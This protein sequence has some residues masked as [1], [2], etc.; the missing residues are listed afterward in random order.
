[1]SDQRLRELERQAQAGGSDERLRRERCRQGE[2]CAGH[3]PNPWPDRA[4]KQF[5]VLGPNWWPVWST[6]RSTENLAQAVLVRDDGS[7]PHGSIAAAGW[8]RLRAQGYRVVQVEV[9]Q[10]G[11]PA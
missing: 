10:I 7:Q 6:M 2:C 1:M 11:E 3:V 4:C 5:V 8:R 9:R